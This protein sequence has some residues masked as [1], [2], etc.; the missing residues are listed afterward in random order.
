M[1]KE[2]EKIEKKK[3][4]W[5][6]IFCLLMVLYLAFFPNFFFE[7]RMVFALT[8]N[9]GTDFTLC[10]AGTS[11]TRNGEN[12]EVT[13]LWIFDSQQNDYFDNDGLPL[14]LEGGV[15][16]DTPVMAASSQVSYWLEV[17]DNSSF[18]SPEIQTGE[19][20]SANQ[21]YYY[22]G[23]I[24]TADRTWFWRVMV[25]DSYNSQTDWV[26]GGPFSFGTKTMLK[27]KIKLKGD[28]RFQF[29]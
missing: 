17:D 22:N 3:N 21:Y 23:L 6:D 28:M 8:L 27:G 19:V 29:P 1:L 14:N 13:F 24:L 16:V 7:P 5:Q 9:A 20:V 15:S 25:K 26:D 2:L 18:T 11:M 4:I 10:T 12:I